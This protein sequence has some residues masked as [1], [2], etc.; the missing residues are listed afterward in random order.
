MGQITME[1]KLEILKDKISILSFLLEDIKQEF[2]DTE[3]TQEE[4]RIIMEESKNR[5]IEL[6]LSK[7]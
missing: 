7:P 6:I 5:L 1:T 3:L 2:E 4:E